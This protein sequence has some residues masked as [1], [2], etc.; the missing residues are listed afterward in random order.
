MTLLAERIA[1]AA[2]AAQLGAVIEHHGEIAAR[3]CLQPSHRVSPDQPRA[4]DAGETAAQLFL[5]RGKGGA[6]QGVLPQ[7]VDRNIVTC[8]FGPVDPVDGD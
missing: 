2:A 3:Q 5:D 6:V 1:E 4:M 7:P 8:R